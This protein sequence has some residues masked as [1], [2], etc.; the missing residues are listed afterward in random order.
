M[1]E[2]LLVIGIAIPIVCKFIDNERKG[3]SASSHHFREWQYWH[4]HMRRERL[5]DYI[6]KYMEKK[7]NA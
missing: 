1:I 3:G 7:H 2:L 4:K 5:K 6:D